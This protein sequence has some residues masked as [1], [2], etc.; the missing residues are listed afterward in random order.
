M[1]LLVSEAETDALTHWMEQGAHHISTTLTETE[2]RRSAQR[3]GFTQMATTA[4]LD[5]L[6]L[7][8]VVR[9]DYS[10]AGHMP[11][12]DLR[13]LDALHLAAALRLGVDRFVT[14]DA[15]QADAAADLGL[16]VVSPR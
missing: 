15:R 2:L 7:F 11:G 3:L 12:R 6:D 10:T 5:R 4:V 1:K 14:Y 16:C 13:S 9:G 8:D